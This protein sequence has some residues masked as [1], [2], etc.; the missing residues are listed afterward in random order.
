M[1]I[2]GIRNNNKIVLHQQIVAFPSVVLQISYNLHRKNGLISVITKLKFWSESV[3][4]VSECLSAVKCAALFCMCEFFCFEVFH[5][6]KTEPKQKTTNERS[7]FSK[8]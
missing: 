3:C 4:K 1:T 5:S 6:E 2:K 7:C 8:W